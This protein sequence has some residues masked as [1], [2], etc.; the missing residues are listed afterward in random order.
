VEHARRGD[1]QL[2]PG[3]SEQSWRM[4]RRFSADVV[5][6]NVR[7][8]KKLHKSLE[9]EAK[10]LGTSINAEVVSRLEKSLTLPSSE[11]LSELLRVVAR[12]YPQVMEEPSVKTLIEKRRLFSQKR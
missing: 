12:R 4:P 5:T 2:S 9:Q 6:T 1:L 8:P 3:G 7:L 11:Q 10:R